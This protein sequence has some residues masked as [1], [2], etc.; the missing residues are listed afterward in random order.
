L[1]GWW[2][3]ERLADGSIALASLE[4]LPER[5]PSKVILRVLRS[6]GAEPAYDE[7][8]LQNGGESVR[9]VSAVQR[10]GVV[11]VVVERSLGAI[12]AFL[13]DPQTGKSS[14]LSLS[15]SEE[16]ARFPAV[17]A[18]ATGFVV[19]W[20]DVAARPAVL[21]ARAI[22]RNSAAMLSSTIGPLAVTPD[23]EPSLGI[24]SEDEEDMFVWERGD[25][26]AQ[27]RLPA[28]LAGFE[29]LSD[30]KERLCSFGSGGGVSAGE[31]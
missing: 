6:H 23:R 12:E 25:G 17:A 24:A 8:V 31:R 10:S 27:R 2:A 13:V 11:A 19:A 14:R 3:A 30:L 28:E 1:R 7:F 21:R 9:I 22:E 26:P 29:L 16:K 5:L 18:T 15:T 20:A 4:G